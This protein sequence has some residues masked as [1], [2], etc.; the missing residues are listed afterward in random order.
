MPDVSAFF[1]HLHHQ[2]DVTVWID[3]VQRRQVQRKLIAENDPQDGHDDASAGLSA[4]GGGVAPHRSE[5][6]FTFTQSHARFLRQTRSQTTQ[7]S[8]GSSALPRILTMGS[9]GHWLAA[10]VKKTAI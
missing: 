3:V 6:Y 7:R 8:V 2:D 1:H 9:P 10:P 5:Q 4:G